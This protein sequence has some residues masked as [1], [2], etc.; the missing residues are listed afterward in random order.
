MIASHCRN[1][2]RLETELNC[3][4][5]LGSSLVLFLYLVGR[6]PNL[7]LRSNL[8]N[9]ELMVLT[10]LDSS[11][12]SKD[13]VGSYPFS[14]GCWLTAPARTGVRRHYSDSRDVHDCAHVMLSSISL[15]PHASRMRHYLDPSH[16]GA[17]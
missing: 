10:R 2:T 5:I 16:R 12:I 8:S 7:C 1:L 4:G 13:D 9:V 3:T 14:A 6:N 15:D 11:L 17:G